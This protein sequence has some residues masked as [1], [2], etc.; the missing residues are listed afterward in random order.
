MPICSVTWEG[1][2]TQAG[3]HSRNASYM[4]EETS[5][6][7]DSILVTWDRSCLLGTGGWNG[8]GIGGD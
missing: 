5:V 4:K 7:E 3:K 2:R 8:E 1:R 6:S